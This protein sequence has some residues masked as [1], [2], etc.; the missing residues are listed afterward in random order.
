MWLGGIEGI[1]MTDKMKMQYPHIQRLGQIF[2]DFQNGMCR[3]EWKQRL[4]VTAG[5][6]RGALLEIA[7]MLRSP[8]DIEQRQ[9]MTGAAKREAV[10]LEL[11]TQEVEA[12]LLDGY[13]EAILGLTSQSPTAGED[14]HVVYSAA[15]IVAVMQQ[16]DGMTAE[17]ARE[18]YLTNIRD[19]YYGPGSPILVDDI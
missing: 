5:E 12:V 6:M 10:T 19:A 9:P 8:A 14:Y 13:D 18:M 17:E 11:E 3:G 7:S 2:A 16:R 15:T 1:F 4:P